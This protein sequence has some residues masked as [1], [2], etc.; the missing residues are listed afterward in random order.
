MCYFF[1]Q[2]LF[3]LTLLNFRLPWLWAAITTVKKI[4]ATK[5]TTFSE[6]PGRKLSYGIPW[7]PLKKFCIGVIG[8][9]AKRTHFFPFS[10]SAPRNNVGGRHSDNFEAT[11]HAHSSFWRFLPILFREHIEIDITFKIWGP[12]PLWSEIIHICV[13]QKPLF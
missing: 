13:H 2:L 3:L 9:N 10:V 11:G 4:I 5:T 12:T 8:P 1:K 7:I 6:S